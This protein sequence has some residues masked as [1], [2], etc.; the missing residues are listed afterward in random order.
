MDTYHKYFQ[1]DSYTPVVQ[2]I[3]SFALGVLLAPLSY[4]FIYFIIFTIIYE[5]IYYHGTKGEFPYWSTSSRFYI[6]FVYI[7]AWWL[8][9]LLVKK[10]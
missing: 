2:I 9:R 6:N 8:G 7:G 3:I 1:N 5:L 4:G 10:I